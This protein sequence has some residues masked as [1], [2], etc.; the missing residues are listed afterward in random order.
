MDVMVEPEKWSLQI[1]KYFLALIA[2][3][4][5][6]P[7]L[8][9]ASNWNAARKA[10][11]AQVEKQRTLA[12]IREQKRQECQ[13]MHAMIDAA[14]SKL[15]SDR[16][17]TK[18]GFSRGVDQLISELNALEI[19]NPKLTNL[20]QNFVEA[21]S[22]ARDAFGP[23]GAVDSELLNEADRSESRL[24]NAFNDFCSSTILHGYEERE[25]EEKLQ[26]AEPKSGTTNPS[27]TVPAFP[28]FG[29]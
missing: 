19:G 7:L 13:Q 28:G 12:L 10:K 11:Q 2:V 23:L 26:L 9:V 20:R 16:E 18:R 8:V 29:K 15:N 1:V 5:S 27:I 3:G 4:T 6:L 24:I 14:S 22:Q 21:Y 17:L 25:G